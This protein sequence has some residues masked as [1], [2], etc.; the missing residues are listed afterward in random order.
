MDPPPPQPLEKMLRLPPSSLWS[1]TTAKP[2][3]SRSC[4][5]THQSSMFPTPPLHLCKKL[6]RLLHSKFTSPPM[7]SATT[8]QSPLEQLK[9]SST[10]RTVATSM[11]PCTLSHTASS[12]LFANTQQQATRSSLEPATASTNS[13]EQYTTMKPRSTTL[14]TG[15]EMWICCPPS[16]ATEDE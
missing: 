13:P 10:W 14:G 2:A 3:T 15:W 9:Q 8:P 1:S 4:P 7:A 5:P 12:P 16:S 6:H 11:T